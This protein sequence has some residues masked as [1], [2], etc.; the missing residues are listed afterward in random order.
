[1]IV[2]AVVVLFGYLLIRREVRFLSGALG[3]INRRGIAPKLMSKVIPRAQVLEERVYGFYQR[4]Q[5]R[6]LSIFALDLCFHLAGVI[7]VYTTLSFISPV[8]PSLTQ[9]FI[10]ESVNRIINVA[11]KFVPLRAGV[12]EGGTGQVSKVLGFAR[13]IGETLAIVRKGRDIFWSSVGVILIWKR[14][15]SLRNLS[16]ETAADL[17]QPVAANE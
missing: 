10:L 3:R 15:L 16:E 12:D 17:S 11:F 1:L 6:F 8:A 7:E 14:G 4:N 9:A 2:T 13:G 5:G